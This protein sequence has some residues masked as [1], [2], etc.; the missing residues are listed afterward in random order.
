MAASGKLQE[1]YSEAAKAECLANVLSQCQS[2]GFCLQSVSVLMQ[3]MVTEDS[4]FQIVWEM[5]LHSCYGGQ[6]LRCLSES[7]EWEHSEKEERKE[8]Q[9]NP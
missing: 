6:L 3:F 4:A 9:L 1:N 5:V 7:H 8:S 2:R